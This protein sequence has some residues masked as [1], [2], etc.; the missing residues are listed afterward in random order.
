MTGQPSAGLEPEKSWVKFPYR[1]GTGGPT[2]ES[3]PS[4]VM[5]GVHNCRMSEPKQ[6]KESIHMDRVCQPFAKLDFLP[7]SLV[8][9]W[10]HFSISPSQ[11]K[12]C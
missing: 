5:E 10:K 11:G 3:G 12:H 8:R 2:W 9:D 4:W 7:L 6:V 1:R